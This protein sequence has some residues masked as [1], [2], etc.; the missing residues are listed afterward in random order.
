MTHTYVICLKAWCSLLSQQPSSKS[1]YISASF[2]ACQVLTLTFRVSHIIPDG[3]PDSKVHGANM[4]PPG[5]YRPQMGPMLAPWILLLLFCWRYTR[6]YCKK[7]ITLGT[8][9]ADCGTFKLNFKL[10]SISVNKHHPW[11]PAIVLPTT[12]SNILLKGVKSTSHFPLH[13]SGLRNVSNYY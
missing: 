1:V 11:W 12:I 2:T 7:N 4:G 5:S 9:P 8:A 10:K 13:I 6:P 3:I